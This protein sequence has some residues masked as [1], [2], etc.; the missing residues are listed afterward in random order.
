[1]K[2]T[3]AVLLTAILCF[4]FVTPVFA[5]DAEP[6]LTEAPTTEVPATTEA[7]VTEVPAT[8]E[9]PATE[10]PAT[11][12]LP[13]TEEPTTEPPTTD[14]PT[15][16]PP[17]T[18][19]PKILYYGDVDKDFRVTSSDARLV[20][21]FSARL[22]TFTNEQCV[23]ADTDKNGKVN[24][25]DARAVLRLCARLDRKTEFDK[26]VAEPDKTVSSYG[27]RKY[28]PT[29]DGFSTNIDD[30]AVFPQIKELEEYCRNFKNTGTFY[31]T[32]V[33]GKY[34][35]SFNG[36]R[37]YRTQCT[38]KA[39]YCKAA[40]AYMEQNGISL[41]TKLTLTASAKW[42]GHRLSG[43]A[44]GTKFTI[45]NLVRFAL[46]YSDNT[47]YQMLFN[48]FGN[49]VLNDNAAALGANLRLGSYIFGETSA[50]D[51]SILYR[52]IYRYCER[53]SDYS[54][55]IKWQ[56]NRDNEEN[57]GTNLLCGGIPKGVTALHKWGNGG[58]ATKGFHDCAI[59]YANKP[60]V[61]CMYT[62]FNFDRN[63]DRVPFRNVGALCY[64]INIATDYGN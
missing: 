44:N 11:T 54:R 43:Y 9:A 24:S 28:E 45:A 27:Y 42:N 39:P 63:G 61:V 15:T 10:V 59:V 3:I 1:M 40:L 34:Y 41:D 60:F 46:T 4:G 26:T 14:E 53:N 58:K 49:K 17:T 2:K 25:T 19:P 29:L 33:D 62:S 22:I 50:Q 36:S 48:H 57:T 32:D 23:L 12:G 37:V 20:L 5:T 31:Y 30:P 13:E 38:V 8:T 7:P 52:D 35:V 51:M 55:H 56:M 6:G 47:A 16:E 64:N 21:R 18:E